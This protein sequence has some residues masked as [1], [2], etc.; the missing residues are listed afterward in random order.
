MLISHEIVPKRI[1]TNFVD[2]SIDKSDFFQLTD[3]SKIHFLTNLQAVNDRYLVDCKYSF[4]QL[5]LVRYWF[6]NKLSGK[7]V[8][9]VDFIAKF[10]KK[11]QQ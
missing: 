1:R 4:A 2:L 3:F 7:F 5:L 6:D 11:C 9:V 8:N 10:T